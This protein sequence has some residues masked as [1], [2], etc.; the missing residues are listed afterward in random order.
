MGAVTSSLASSLALGSFQATC[1]GVWQRPFGI[2]R[3]N[4]S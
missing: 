2:L 3:E 4:N 1:F